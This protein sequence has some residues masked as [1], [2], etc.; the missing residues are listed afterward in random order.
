MGAVEALILP[1]APLLSPR[2][3]ID[4]LATST[5]ASFT[6]IDLN[7]NILSLALLAPLKLLNRSIQRCHDRLIHHRVDVSSSEIVGENL[8]YFFDGV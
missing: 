7:L 6:N 3:A 2:P 4:P 8:G 1:R 5:P